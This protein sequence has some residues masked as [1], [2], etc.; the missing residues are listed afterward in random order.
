MSTQNTPTNQPGMIDART[1]ASTGAIGR[2]GPERYY[3]EAGAAAFL[4][5][6][7]EFAE[8]AGIDMGGTE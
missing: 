8:Q 6:M 7:H 1:F 2:V 5:D 3:T 4:R